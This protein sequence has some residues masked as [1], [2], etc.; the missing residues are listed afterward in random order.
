MIG[1]KREFFPTYEEATTRHAEL[2]LEYGIL[3]E[4]PF[5]DPEFKH[6]IL[7]WGSPEKSIYGFHTA[8]EGEIG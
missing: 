4:P 6:W 5:H 7:T 3:L 8:N 2:N 1:N